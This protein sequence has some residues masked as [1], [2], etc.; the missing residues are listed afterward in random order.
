MST[1]DRYRMELNPRETVKYYADADFAADRRKCAADY[2]VQV[3][4]HV[5]LY[6]AEKSNPVFSSDAPPEPEPVAEEPTTGTKRKT[7]TK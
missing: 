2:A 3:E 6:V 1:Q 7:V 5:D 4:A